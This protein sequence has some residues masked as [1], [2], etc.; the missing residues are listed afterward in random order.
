MRDRD[1]RHWRALVRDRAKAE[2]RELSLDVIDELA[3]HLADLHAAALRDGATEE[4]AEH[5][6]LDALRSAS[7]LELSKRPRA[8][9][10]PVGY[11]HD[12]RLAFRQLRATP[13]VTIVAVLSLALGIGANTTMFSLVDSLVLRALP[14]KEPGR[15]AIVTDTAD[16]S[17]TTYRIWREIERRHLFDRAFAWR[18]M[19]FNLAE[20]GETDLVDGIWASAGIFD[21]M[22]VAPMLGRG[23]VEADD[24]RGGGPDGAVVVISYAFWRQRFGAAL[25]AIGRHVTIERGFAGRALH[26]AARHYSRLE[27]TH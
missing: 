12:L 7:F 11:M 1:L 4:E 3:C 27:Q 26:R 21:T 25:D 19:R 23:F 20:R 6:A 9:R 24:R 15:L 5:R 16:R 10:S 13:V 18:D 22:G 14:V 8:R 2:W 17:A